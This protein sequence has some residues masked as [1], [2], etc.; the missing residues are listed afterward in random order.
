MAKK[1]RADVLLHERGDAAKKAYAEARS[2]ATP[3]KDAIFFNAT[4]ARLV[5]EKRARRSDYEAL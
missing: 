5:D 1:V 3:S 2:R 4:H